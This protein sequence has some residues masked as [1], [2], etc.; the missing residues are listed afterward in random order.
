MWIELAKRYAS[1]KCAVVLRRRTHCTERR[2]FRSI[3]GALSKAS[4]TQ[5]ATGIVAIYPCVTAAGH[6]GMMG[7][8]QVYSVNAQATGDLGR[9]HELDLRLTRVESVAAMISYEDFFFSF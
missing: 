7:Y 5:E 6:W 2:L 3:D 4:R 1:D 8:V 9:M